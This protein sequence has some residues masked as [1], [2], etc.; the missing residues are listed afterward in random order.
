MEK[1]LTAGRKRR[2]TDTSDV[3][4]QRKIERREK[5]PETSA[6]PASSSAHVISASSSAHV[7]SA[8]R[9]DHTKFSFPN[10]IGK[11]VGR[12]VSVS[13]K[14]DILCCW[15]PPSSYSFP[16]LHFRQ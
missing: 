5:M 4:E 13:D 3:A 1:F 8:P 11:F 2:Q 15:T 9:V 14:N 16:L 6:N 12:V 10:D 7:I